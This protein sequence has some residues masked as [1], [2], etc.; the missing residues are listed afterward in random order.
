ME[1]N[2][3]DNGDGQRGTDWDTL[4]ILTSVTPAGNYHSLATAQTLADPNSRVQSELT[5]SGQEKWYRLDLLGG[6]RTAEA[7][8]VG[9]GAA[10]LRLRL[11]RQDGQVLAETIAGGPGQPPARIEQHL[12]AGRY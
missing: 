8:A 1:S 9:M 12:E 2:T 10:G 3:L 11:L 7:S 5:A 6:R 4:T